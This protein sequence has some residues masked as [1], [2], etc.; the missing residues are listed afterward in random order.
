MRVELPLLS[1]QLPFDKQTGQQLL[2]HRIQPWACRYSVMVMITVKAEAIETP[3]PFSRYKRAGKKEEF[4]SFSSNTL[5][6]V[7]W[8]CAD[9]CL[10]MYALCMCVYIYI[11]DCTLSPEC[12]MLG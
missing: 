1:Q 8:L 3:N 5:T 12:S 6:R 9:T 4:V 7:S 10:C 11:Q 2:A